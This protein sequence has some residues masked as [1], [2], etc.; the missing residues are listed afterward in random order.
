MKR[1][2]SVVVVMALLFNCAYMPRHYLSYEK[3][4]PI[5]ISALVG[6]TIDPE[7]RE[8][9]DLF[10]GIE[11][12]KSAMF[13][14]IKGGGYEVE[15]VTDRGKYVAVNRDLK[16]IQILKDYF[17]RYDE[18]SYNQKAF[19]NRWKIID[20]D[21]LGFAISQQE[22]DSHTRMTCC[23]GFS[24]GCGLVSLGLSLFMAWGYGL[25]HMNDS[26]QSAVNRICLI[27]VIGGTLAGVVTGALSGGK[28]DR[29]RAI[30]AI[31]EARMP[32]LMR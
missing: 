14:G 15:I 12:F 7:E 28:M 9:F 22:V 24:G 4:R 5:V 20:Y 10:H 27:I 2:I 30:D 19:E 17:Y 25:N 23:V 16:A 32:V 1:R 11:D 3:T 31:R 6:E 18:T 13:Y 26:D 29:D 8:K 21:T